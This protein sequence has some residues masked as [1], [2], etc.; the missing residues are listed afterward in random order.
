MSEGR[1]SKG[2]AGIGRSP[3]VR[4]P[5]GSDQLNRFRGIG[6]RDVEAY[7]RVRR[8]YMAHAAAGAPA[9]EVRL[10]AL[11]TSTESSRYSVG[12]RCTSAPARM[13][14]SQ[15]PAFFRTLGMAGDDVALSVRSRLHRM[16]L[17]RGRCNALCRRIHQPR[18]R[19]CCVD[20]PRRTAWTRPCCK[21]A[22]QR[23]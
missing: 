22:S 4:C 3:S 9:R 16:G 2:L 23:P 18:L 5:R 21:T 15:E 13:G 12:V 17:V 10:P 6:G 19:A 11:A 1:R 20:L 7:I 8:L 14:E